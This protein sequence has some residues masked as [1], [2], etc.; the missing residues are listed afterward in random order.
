MYQIFR[1]ASH[2]LKMFFIRPLSIILLLSPILLSVLTQQFFGGE[3][4]QSLGS[5]GISIQDTSSFTDLF[6]KLLERQKIEMVSYES[7]REIREA[8]QNDDITIGLIGVSSNSYESIQQGSLP[9]KIIKKDKDK[10][11][12][13]IIGKVENQLGQLK[14]LIDE[15]SDEE[16]FQK[17]YASMEVS[18]PAMKQLDTVQQMNTMTI[19]FS[20]FVMMFLL[21]VGVGLSPMMSERESEVYKRICTTPIK[22][23]Q[24]MLGHLIGAFVIVFGQML[25]QLMMMRLLKVDFN[26]SNLEFIIIGS[27][28]CIVGLAISLLILAV[29]KNSTMYYMIMGIGVTPLCMLSDTFFPVEFFPEWLEKLAYL[30]PIRWIMSAYKAMIYNKG[31]EQIIEGFIIALLISTVMILISLAKKSHVCDD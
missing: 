19:I 2:N 13:Q 21:T 22:Y 5:I 14:L 24:Y 27:G 1:V 17:L 9:Y 3:Q 20:F 25:M 23:Y 12:D 18:K 29:S 6:E 28:L 16:H 7:E 15:T 4:L 8:V 31:S 10:K 11:A 26:L 30:S